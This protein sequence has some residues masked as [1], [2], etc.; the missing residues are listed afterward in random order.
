MAK[1]F[2]GVGHGGND[3]GAV[4]YIKEK[5][6][7]LN[8]ALACRDYLVNNG[9]QVKM[10]RTKDENDP[11][12]DEIKE[13]NAYNPDLAIDIHN[14]AGGGEGAE[15]YYHHEG[16]T[17]KKLAENIEKQIIAIGQKSRGCKIKLNSRGNADYYGF[18]RETKPA[19]VIVE[20]VFVDNKKD[21]SKADTLEEQKA[22]GIAIAKGIMN[23]LGIKEKTSVKNSYLVKINTAVLN[24]RDRASTKYKINTT[25]KE[26]EVY[27][28]VDEKNGWGKLKSGAGWIKLSYTKKMK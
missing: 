19:A 7:N 5:D 9:I 8:M 23:T 12:T 25:V 15:V 2:L 20:C 13:C 17:S 21:A 11:L 3:P 14:N 18:I 28:I 22:F 4:K 24:V 26:N 6:V 16:K 27:T 10:S 1:V